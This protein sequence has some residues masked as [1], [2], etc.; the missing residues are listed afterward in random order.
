VPTTVFAATIAWVAS[1]FLPAAT[2]SI[3]GYDAFW[4]SFRGWSEP[5]QWDLE[6]V[7]LVLAWLANVG[8][9]S[10][11]TILLGKTARAL[12]ARSALAGLGV[13]VLGPPLVSLGDLRVGYYLWALAILWL[14]SLAFGAVR[15]AAHRGG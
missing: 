1:F 11:L 2:E 9:L 10:A 14:T 7:P 4:L 3:R 15:G 5:G 13:L 12:R 8:A 6:S